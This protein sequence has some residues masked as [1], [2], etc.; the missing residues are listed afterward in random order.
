MKLFKIKV[1]LAYQMRINGKNDRFGVKSCYC[2]KK[3][4]KLRL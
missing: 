2:G 4:S 3:M 1:V